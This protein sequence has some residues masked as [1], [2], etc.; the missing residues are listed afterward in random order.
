[1]AQYFVD[2]AITAQ[3][4]LK[5]MNQYE[6]AIALLEEIDREL[7]NLVA[8]GYRTET[9]ESKFT[10]FYKQFNSNVGRTL[11]GL[12]GIAQ[13]VKSVGDSFGELDRTMGTNLTA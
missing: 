13:Y 8:T 1:M 2:D 10:P 5:T 9:S 6:Q 3:T 4:S 12:R 7:D 11:E